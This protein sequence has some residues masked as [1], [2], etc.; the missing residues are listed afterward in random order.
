MRSPRNVPLHDFNGL[1]VDC[2]TPSMRR[3]VVV[4]RG[5]LLAAQTEFTV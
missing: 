5:G 3:L 1:S 4:K 2:P